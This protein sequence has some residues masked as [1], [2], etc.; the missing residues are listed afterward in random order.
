MYIVL[1]IYDQSNRT[2]VSDIVCKFNI[3]EVFSDGKW[4]YSMADNA[5]FEFKNEFRDELADKTEEFKTLIREK[6]NEILNS[7]RGPS[8]VSNPVL[9]IAYDDEKQKAVIL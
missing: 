1:N 7:E 6:V 2:V 8:F 4:T 5:K 3:K 9:R